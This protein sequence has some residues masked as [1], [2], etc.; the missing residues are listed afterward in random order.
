VFVFNGISANRISASIGGGKKQPRTPKAGSSSSTG[1]GRP[2][3]AK[4]L[5][6]AK[7]REERAAEKLAEKRR[8][9]A[10]AAQKK[11]AKAAERA[12]SLQAKE[13]KLR[14]GK[15]AQKAAA[16]REQVQR[17]H[18][19]NAQIEV[20]PIRLVSAEYVY[21]TLLREAE[22]LKRCGGDQEEDT[23]DKYY[24]QLHAKLE[25]EEKN[26]SAQSS[27]NIVQWVIC[28]NR[29]C[30]KWR[31]VDTDRQLHEEKKFFCGYSKKKSKEH[32]AALD[33]WVL[34][35]VGEGLARKCADIGINTV[36]VLP[37]NP[38]LLKKLHDLGMWYEAEAQAIKKYS[39]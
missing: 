27:D 32:C 5:A 24:T 3:S 28:D 34:R 21:A 1:P 23:S 36:D 2:L 12:A 30:R 39:N 35:C 6:A 16:Q 17:Q 31:V 20:P 10:A 9:E 8:K 11:A 7:K 33:D 37:N 22:E 19:P 18:A 15:R 38:A 13:A 25:V 14:E 26:Q 4:A 29:K